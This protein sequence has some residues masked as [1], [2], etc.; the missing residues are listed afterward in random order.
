MVDK[1]CG[2]IDEEETRK[3]LYFCFLSL[4][5]LCFLFFSPFLVISISF[6]PLVIPDSATPSSSP[7]G[8]RVPKN[9]LHLKERVTFLCRFYSF[10]NVVIVYT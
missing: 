5:S 3:L 10:I 4:V 1:Q 9:M 6:C 8:E 2:K 7:Q